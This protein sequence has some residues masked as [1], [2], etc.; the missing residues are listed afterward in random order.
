M[1]QSLELKVGM[2]L[3]TEI[4]MNSCKIK[5]S[6]VTGCNSCEI[7]AILNIGCMTDFSKG[8]CPSVNTHQHVSVRKCRTTV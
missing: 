8:K 4:E 6:K 7:G 1:K 5:N 3:R 2:K